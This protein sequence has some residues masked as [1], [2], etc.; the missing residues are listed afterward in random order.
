LKL[1][2]GWLLIGL[3]G[4]LGN[5]AED[6]N[7]FTAFFRAFSG[8]WWAWIT[9]GLAA[10]IGIGLYRFFNSAEAQQRA[11]VAFDVA[12][13]WPRRHH[14]L[15]PPPYAARV[16][17]DLA[18]VLRNQVNAGIR[19]AIVGHSQGSVLSYSAL[20]RASD[21]VRMGISLITCGSPLASLYAASF[22][23]YF[24]TEEF[25][26][27]RS[28]LNPTTVEKASGWFNLYRDTDPLG[29]PIFEQSGIDSC[30]WEILEPEPGVRLR[31]HGGYWED[32]TMISLLGRVLERSDARATS[33]RPGVEY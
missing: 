31:R 11:A 19:V 8:N 7:S 5:F 12:G 32:A 3:A 24:S 14:P 25:K 21:D 4:W 29:T 9:V 18:D 22:P 28:R 17:K 26:R 27:L 33:S 10:L 23:G 15:A 16:V 13:F 1:V 2:L 20:L 6:S 30:D